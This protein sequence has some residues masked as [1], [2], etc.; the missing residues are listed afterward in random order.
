MTLDLSAVRSQFPAVANKNLIYLDNP[1]GT[2]VCQQTLDRVTKYL[3]DTNAN[4]RGAFETARES[5]RVIDEARAACKDFYNAARDEEIVFGGNMTTLALHFSRSLAHLFNPGDR[6]VVTR[7]DHDAN[8]TPWT[9]VAEE[10]GCEVDWVDFDVETGTLNRES[11][12]R[13]LEKKPKLVAVGYASNALG[14][15]NPVKSITKMAK[16]VGALV[17]IDAV[18]YAPHGITDVQELGCD[19]LV[20]SAY[21]WFSTHVGI[22]YGR[23]DLLES[24]KAYKVRPAPKDSPGK[25]ETG[26]SNHEGIAGVLGALEYF[27]WLGEQFGGDHLERYQENFSGRALRLRQGMAA[28]RAYEFE[29]NRALLEV[30][31]SIPEVTIYG[32]TDLDLLDE[33]VP[34]FSINVE[35]FHPRELA[36]AFGERGVQVWHG[37]YYALAVTQRLGVEDS[38]GMVRIGGVHYN[39]VEEIY[40]MGDVL[41]EIIG[42]GS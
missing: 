35:G 14:T 20:S 7:M 25:W 42:A 24:L 31:A 2:Q 15:I 36:E 22:L 39:T 17:F 13:A 10:R 3:V 37:N 28:I 41:K 23:Y 18:Q 40:R 4:R 6:F 8:I 19:F 12:E 9:L 32:P 30:L 1:A 29:I 11:M 21:K 33:R 34:T 5:D 16:E 27:E 26:T 38:G